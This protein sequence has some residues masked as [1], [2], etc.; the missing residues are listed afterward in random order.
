M[1]RVLKIF[2]G[3]FL[4]FFAMM[5]VTGVMINRYVNEGY[6]VDQIEASINS[7][8]EIGNVEVSLLSLPANVT[9]QD[10]RL[11]RKNSDRH[12]AL[13]KVQKIDL[14]VSLWSLLWKRI[15]VTN[16][17]IQ[18]AHVTCTAYEEGGTSLEALFESPQSKERE[19][20][21]PKPRAGGEPRKKDEREKGGGFNVMDHEDFVAA[22]GGFY[23]EDCSVD[24]TLEKTG[25]RIRCRDL[26]LALS[27]LE[28]DPRQLAATDI[29]QMDLGVHVELDSTKGW[30][31]GELDIQGQAKARIF[32]P[33]TGDMEPDVTGE[34]ALAET[35]WLNTQVPLITNAWQKLGQL[36][37]IG[38]KIAPLPE[39]A[40]FGRS[41]AVAAHYHLGKITLHKSLSL[42]VDDWELAVIGGSWLQTETDIHAIMG[43]LLASRN[44]SNRFHALIGAALNYLPKEIQEKVTQEIEGDLFRG[45]RLY[46]AIKSSGELSDP[47]IR[48]VDGVP[49]FAKSAEKA[50]KKLLQ[51]KTGGLLDGL[52]GR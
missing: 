9:L 31:Y 21:A 3:L 36:E 50:G 39:K 13:I 49:D 15:E 14:S 29:A 27:S 41:E 48:L 4:V 43:E 5:A 16:I 1:N 26:N 12:D 7:E 32:N 45:E 19:A 17:T 44:T 42:W 46:L 47:K 33:E 6:L 18:G 10:V 35:S 38:I 34:F 2:L 28:I 11:T 52:F 8:V 22:L 24:L 37:K 25:L 30:R 20:R 23:L 40:T 51:E